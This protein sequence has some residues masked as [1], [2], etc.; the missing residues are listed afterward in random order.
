VLKNF[1]K[2]KNN[3]K[4]FYFYFF[5]FNFPEEI[6]ASTHAIEVS[7]DGRYISF[8]TFNA[9]NVPYYKIPIYGSVND[10]YTSINKIAYPKVFCCCC[11]F[12][13]FLTPK[14]ISKSIDS[15]FSTP[16]SVAIF[17]MH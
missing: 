5:K 12:I 15:N 17:P 13:Y 11:Y 7:R 6:I 3:K 2:N 4:Y 9:T 14:S 10:Q 8:V 16:R 1:N